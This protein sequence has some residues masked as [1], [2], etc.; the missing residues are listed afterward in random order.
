MVGV[1]V[2]V[3]AAPA[4]IFVE[5]ALMLTAGATLEF[6]VIV[7]LLEL[8]VVVPAHGLVEVNW[9]VTASPLTNEVV[10]KE[11]ALVPTLLPFTFH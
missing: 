3:T 4:Q 5:V 8:T 10:L 9:Q 1:A 11:D 6:T 7:T 2:K